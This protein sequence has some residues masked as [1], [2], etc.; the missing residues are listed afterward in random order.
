MSEQGRQ[1][2]SGLPLFAGA[3]N[4][5][6]PAGEGRLPA[7]G[8][9]VRGQFRLGDAE[10]APLADLPVGVVSAEDVAVS[11]VAL[12]LAEGESVDWSLVAA[13]RAQA[14]EQLTRVLG[15][16][17]THVS[18]ELQREQG[19]A[20]VL[21]LLDTAA[22]T[23]I[24]QGK[25][26]WSPA[27]QQRL[28]QAVFD[29]LFRLGRLQPLV[30]DDRVENII[31]DGCDRVWLGLTDGSTVPGPA[32]ADS[33]QELIDFLSFLASRS[34]ANARSFSEA[35]PSLHLRLDGGYRL[36]ATA[37]VVPRPAVVIRRHRLM[38]E[39][40]DDLVA[41]QSLSPTAAS[42]LK[43]AVR[44]KL[45]IIVAGVQGVG[46]TTMMRALAAE[47][48][49]DEVLGTFETEYELH[50]HELHNQDVVFAWEARPGSGEVMADGRGAGEYTTLEQLNDSF[51]FILSRQL[52][53]EVRGPEAWPMLKAMESGP[54]S[55][56]T[57]HAADAEGAIGKLVTCAMEAGPHVTSELAI[58]K[59]AQ[60]VDLVVYLRTETITDERGA[61]QKVRWVSEIVH[62]TPGESEKGYA[63][64][65]V[66]HAPA[67]SYVA[68]PRVMPEPLRD[69][70][71][72]GFDVGEF[73]AQ[74]DRGR[75]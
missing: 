15:E 42:F 68:V 6:Q 41:R 35:H 18:A 44:A 71:R 58:R 1:P 45:S 39:T 72:S 13:F 25:K 5:A 9:R 21:E 38:R 8:G 32:V 66:F 43:A 14:S 64:T 54:G 57:T 40:L 16:D 65:H 17:R 55:M 50:L 75:A 60:V 4:S 2:I 30:E 12:P 11:G 34:E 46:K 10:R 48:P 47:I 3:G 74:A 27:L 28:A 49:R 51:R 73:F 61:T 56:C 7:R 59:L 36:A 67:G 53:G 31:I 23:L 19:R 69:L 33:D 63:L 26:A 20:I 37:W 22:M 24:D 70:S 29:A 62:V 52:V